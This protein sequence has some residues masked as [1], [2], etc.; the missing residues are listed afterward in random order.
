MTHNLFVAYKQNW[1]A[2][3]IDMAERSDQEWIRQLKQDDP[4]SVQALWEMIYRFAWQAAKKR[5]ADSDMAHEAAIAAYN[6]IRQ[7]GVTQY[8]YSGPFAGYCRVIVVRELLR[9]YRKNPNILVTESEHIEEIAVQ[10][11]TVPSVDLEAV[12]NRLKPCLD[13]LPTNIKE[14]VELLYFQGLDPEHAA[15]KLNIRRNYVNQLAHRARKQLRSCLEGYG[16][17]TAGDV[18]SL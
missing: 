4:A 2:Q 5:Q 18:F 14:V 9:L 6:R 13:K 1:S 12:Q 7:R 3:K 16:Y 11:N 10:S 17:L 8:N 15:K